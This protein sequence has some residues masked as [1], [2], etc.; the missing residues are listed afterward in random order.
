MRYA[1]LIVLASMLVGCA[2]P[3]LG[4]WTGPAVKGMPAGAKTVD[5]D[6]NA[7]K[8]WRMAINDKAGAAVESSEG[9]WAERNRTTVDLQKGTGSEGTAQGFDGEVVLRHGRYGLVHMR[10]AK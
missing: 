8:S 9:T 2:S 7:D 3:Y 10:S 6:I 4:R 1:S 5:L